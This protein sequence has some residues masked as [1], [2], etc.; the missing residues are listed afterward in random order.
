MDIAALRT[1]QLVAQHHSF[2]A[3]ARVLDV[4]PSSVSRTV[5]GIE[6]QLGLRLFQRSTR[7]LTLTEAGAL[8]LDRIGPLLDDLDLARDA[9]AEISTRPSGRVRLTASVAFGHDMIV[10]LLSDLRSALPEI[11]LELILSDQTVDLV[12]GQIDLAIRLAPAPKGDL[13]SAR[14]CATRYRVVAAPAYVQTHGAPDTPAGLSA[15]QCLRMTL[16]E[17][18]TEWR[19]RQQQAETVVGV[20]GPILISN[21]LALRAAARNGLGPAL[22]ADWM[23]QRDLKDGR[24]VDL[25]PD[26]QVTATTF[27]T[28]AWL[29]YPSRA[30]LPAK[31][32]AV[33]DFLRARLR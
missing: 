23:T 2:A 31:V 28:G 25:F 14:L 30:Y 20:T 13:I 3:V 9:A 10:P 4:D 29:L 26:H 15:H 21:A 32:R 22:L 1:V 27:D 8:Y 17:Y 5:A 33:I 11:A 18:R 19:F 16:P 24:L 6:A 12:G 7:T